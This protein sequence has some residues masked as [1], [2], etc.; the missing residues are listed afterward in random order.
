[1]TV[2]ILFYAQFKA[3]KVGKT[4]ITV[5]VD[6]DSYA[7]SDGT[8]TAL[9][10]AGSATEGRDGVYFYRYATADLSLT[11]LTCVFKTSDA[12]VDDQQ[13]AAMWSNYSLSDSAAIA[14]AA[15]ASTAL[16]NTTWTDVRAGYLDAAVSS[17]N[18]TTPPTAVAIR[19]EMDANSSKLANLDV[20]VGSR[21]ATSGYTAPD[22]VSI[23]AIKTRTDTIGS[24]TVTVVSPVG[25]TTSVLSL[26]FGD[27]YYAAD[28]R[29]LDFTVDGGP[30]LSGASVAFK[31]R[32]ATL[33]TV[34]ASVL[35][36]SSIRVELSAAN[37]VAMG[38]G[39]A[40]YDIQATLVSSHVVTL[41]AGTVIVSPDVR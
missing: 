7:R 2:A 9:V 32:G 19:T 18:A 10:T 8:R 6:V 11:D 25:V 23:A 4:G 31:V 21:L 24:G 38:V 33:V 39:A 40:S 29:S 12:T 13:I 36:A 30:D 5:T 14:A 41:V 34:A 1:M 35:G 20:N 17:R 22:N 3:S 16:I 27:D 37:V 28:G 15:P 26:V